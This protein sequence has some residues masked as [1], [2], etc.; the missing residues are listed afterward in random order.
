MSGTWHKDVCFCFC[1]SCLFV[2]RDGLP[3]KRPGCALRPPSSD[4][5]PLPQSFI[6]TIPNLYAKVSHP[7]SFDLLTQDSRVGSISRPQT[8]EMEP[9]LIPLHVT[10]A[11][12]DNRVL[13]STIF[14]SSSSPQSSE[15][16]PSQ[17]PPWEEKTISC[18]CDLRGENVGIKI[19]AERGTARRM[20]R[21]CRRIVR[22]SISFLYI[23]ESPSPAV[24]YNHSHVLHYLFMRR[25]L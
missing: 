4:C 7:M 17:D 1:S 3:V 12:I 9:G 8:S 21:D 11:Y 18:H 24:Q 5:P 6:L 16:S 25:R 2:N 23:T 14:M 13:T 22:I 20:E 10:G 19:C 15:P